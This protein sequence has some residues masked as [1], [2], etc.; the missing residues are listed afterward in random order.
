M[1]SEK[2]RE[3]NLTRAAGLHLAELNKLAYSADAIYGRTDKGRNVGKNQKL[4]EKKRNFDWFAYRNRQCKIKMSRFENCW[5]T[6][7]FMMS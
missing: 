6:K 3:A 4:Q 1:S 7:K 5:P 2:V